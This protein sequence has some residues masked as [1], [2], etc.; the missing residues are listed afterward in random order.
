MGSIS[1]G[2][3]R[4]RITHMVAI[5]EVGKVIVR[6][7]LVLV[8]VWI[9]GMKFTGYEAMAFSLWSRTVPW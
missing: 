5:D 3:E 4:T 1:V 9:G 8:L 6:Y 7:G 2:I